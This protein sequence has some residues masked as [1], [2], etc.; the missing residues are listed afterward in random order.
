MVRTRAVARTWAWA[1]AQTRAWAMARTRVLTLYLFVAAY[2]MILFDLV[3][4]IEFLHELF[5]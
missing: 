2:H 5:S 1:V 3:T 4:R